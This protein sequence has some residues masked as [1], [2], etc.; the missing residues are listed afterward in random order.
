LKVFVGEYICGGGCSQ[1][2]IEEIPIGMRREGRAMLSAIVEDLSAFAATT[3]ITDPRFGLEFK[4][5]KRVDFDPEKPIWAQWVDAAQGCDAAVLIAP[6]SGGVLAMGVAA[7]RSAGIDVVAGSGDFLR[8]AGDKLLTAQVMHASGIPHPTYLAQEDQKLLGRFDGATKCVVKPRDGCGTQAIEVFDSF[9]EA[10]EKLDGGSI[11]QG[12][13]PGRS[14]SISYLASG[15]NQ[16]FLPAVSQDIS[17]D[18]CHY[19]GGCGPLGDKLQRRAAALASQAIAAMPP[20]ARGFVGL[21]LILGDTPSDDVVIEINAR[22]TT[23]YVG[24]RKMIHG[25]L[26]ARLFDIE[27]GP[28]R[29]RASVNSVRWTPSGEVT[30]HDAPVTA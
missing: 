12:W 28:V 2:P 16:T 13:V 19:T 10:R 25:N 6:E 26:A 27:T 18:H 11:L 1:Q 9:E 23:S 30:M 5:N 20:R 24:L 15:A 7:L 29:C 17:D 22:L 21:D 3:V 4:S 8:V 14:V